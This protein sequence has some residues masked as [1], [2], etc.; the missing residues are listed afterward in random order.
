MGT[1]VV[2]L[3]GVILE[4][5]VAF[6]WAL[7]RGVAP[8]I[9]SYTVSRDCA[10]LLEP[11]LGEPLDLEIDGDKWRQIYA[12]EIRASTEP[13]L[14]RVIIADRRWR[15]PYAHIAQRFNIRRATGDRLLLNDQGVPELVVTEP[16]LIYEPTTL[17]PPGDTPGTVPW[18]ARQILERIIS[19]P[20]PAGLG[21]SVRLIG[22]EE[23]IEVQDLDL[24]D[25]GSDAIERVLSY[26]GGVEIH[27]DREGNVVVEDTRNNRGE[28]IAAATAIH[29]T[30]GP[31]TLFVSRSIVRPRAVASLFTVDSECRF[32]FSE[33]G[34]Q[35][36]FKDDSNT[37]FNICEVTD[38]TLSVAGRTLPR[39]SIAL[40]ADILAAFGAFGYEDKTLTLERIRKNICED[41]GGYI[42]KYWGVTTAGTAD[43]V[44]QD[45]VQ[46]VLA[47]W[48]R[49]YR[50]APTFWGRLES[51]AAVR[52][53][54]QNPESGSRAPAVAYA[55]YIRL[56][57]KK[58]LGLE[59]ARVANIPMDAAVLGHDGGDLDADS[60][61]APFR[62]AVRDGSA[63]VLE[64]ASLRNPF[65]LFDQTLLGYPEG[66]VIPT[67]DGL[68]RANE[69]RDLAYANWAAVDLRAAFELAIIVSVTPGTP[70]NRARFYSLETAIP[71][72]KGPVL[73]S[74]I[75][76]GVVT[77][78]FA[79]A[80]ARSSEILGA[81]RGQGDWQGLAD[82]LNNGEHVRAVHAANVARV[83][84]LYRDR[85]IGRHDIDRFEPHLE[86][87]G[88]L[89]RVRWV[90]GGGAKATQLEYEEPAAPVGLYRFLDSAT[91]RVLQRIAVTREQTAVGG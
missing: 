16:D 46:A 81:I 11:L 44:F 91:R 57:S 90:M 66:D 89:S 83:L 23:G 64:L 9:H 21:E 42:E 14:R 55:D 56:P 2:K 7:A 30:T 61:P 82:L 35:L 10:A 53:A 69:R 38:Q 5:H 47:A 63:G 19:E 68:G 18:T 29:L 32:N 36:P 33:S 41:F 12:L 67:I 84:D 34:T 70:Q 4:G 72:G 45:R 13:Y 49:L 8:V 88:T 62:V 20:E 76:P 27:L 80:D 15:W 1:P 37:L 25:P 3:G 86:P 40:F 78:R 58:V 75:Y 54:L 26:L 51:V 6:D 59:A 17:F 77:A 52:A 24:D 50:I 60:R 74:R 39:G 43:S 65:G 85:R 71:D 73:Y 87:T 31:E 22:V 28:E 48:R 79:W